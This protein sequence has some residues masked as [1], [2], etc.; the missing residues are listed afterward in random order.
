MDGWRRVSDTEAATKRYE[1]MR[2]FM[3]DPR[4]VT[5]MAT[6]QGLID[7]ANAAW[8][9]RCATPHISGGPDGHR[10]EFLAGYYAREAE[11]TESD[12]ADEAAAISR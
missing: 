5:T 3:H 2:H 12:G 10:Q 7:R 6:D 1:D 9:R 4:T 11:L 8:K